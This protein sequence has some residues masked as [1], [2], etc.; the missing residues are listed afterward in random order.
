MAEE[1]DGVINPDPECN[2]SDHRNRHPDG[3]AEPTHGAK[4]DEYCDDVRK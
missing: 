4:K 3:D 2:G 1:M